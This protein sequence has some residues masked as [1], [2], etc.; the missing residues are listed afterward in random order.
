MRRRRARPQL[1]PWSDDEDQRLRFML[2]CG[3]A[4]DFWKTEFPDRR[5]GEVLERRLELRIPPPREL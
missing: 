2:G 1:R 4:A 3:L 5:F